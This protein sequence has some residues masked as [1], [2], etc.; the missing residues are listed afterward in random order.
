MNVA[1]IDLTGIVCDFINILF[2]FDD[3]TDEGGLRKDE[4]GTKK[5]SDIVL[6]SLHHPYT[7]KTNFKCGRVFSEYASAF[8]IR[9]LSLIL[10]RFPPASGP[11]LS[12]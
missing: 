9:R 3:L 2:A 6:N 7:Y 5:A 8:N 11:A 10:T 4:Q 12:D 1:D